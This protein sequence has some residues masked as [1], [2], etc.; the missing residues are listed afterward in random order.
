MGA[1]SA[2]VS[3]IATGVVI[4]AFVS[5]I[6]GVSVF[7]FKGIRSKNVKATG[8]AKL[9]GKRAGE[10]RIVEIAPGVTMTFCWC[11]SGKFLMGS[12][13]SEEGRS[14][15]EDQ[16]EVTLS[17]GFWMSRTEVT[18]VQW[19][20][21]MNNNPSYFKGE[22]RPVERVSWH[23]AQKFI[24]KINASFAFPDGMQMALPTEAQWEYAC[25]AG[26]T[27]PYS[28]GSIDKV[29]WYRN[30]SGSET[31]RVGAKK[32]NAW[33]LHDMHGNVS[34]WCADWYGE[35]L[36]GGID[37]QGA[38]S[39]SYRVVRGGGWSS[40]ASYCRVA[41]RRIYHPPGSISYIGLR[42]ARS[43]VSLEPAGVGRLRFP[44]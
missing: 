29:A 5:G 32:P 28:G 37:P 8:Y 31:H 6:I 43:S 7:T 33:G 12:P 21:V 17:R 22:N 1:I 11:P 4:G 13:K 35:E 23:D 44:T 24:S 2:V 41:Y 38:T 27:D 40:Y 18:Q 36:V 15:C 39:G 34:D 30:N 26:G 14:D 19:Q 10:E 3:R 25:R 16:V 42:V 20:A 9:Q